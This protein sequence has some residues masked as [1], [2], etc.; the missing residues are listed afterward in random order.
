[1]HNPQ[2]KPESTTN[3]RYL[4]ATHEVINQPK[5]LENY[6]LYDQDPA[7]REAVVREGA[8][9]ASDD[10]SRFGA[11]AGKAETIELGNQ[12]NANKPTFRTHDRYGHRVDEVSFHPAYHELMRVALENGLQDRKST[13]LNS[14]HVR[15][16]YAVFCLKKKNS[17]TTLT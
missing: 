7:L 6:N 11:W 9:H 8:G 3:N 12:A 4:S 10:L 14:S 13:R 2:R 1:M 5:P 16:S 17:T 15:I